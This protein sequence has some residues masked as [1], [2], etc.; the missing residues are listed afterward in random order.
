MNTRP[1]AIEASNAATAAVEMR[2]HSVP[3]TTFWTS[4]TSMVPSPHTPSVLTSVIVATPLDAI[5]TWLCDMMC[6]ATHQYPNPSSDVTTVVAN[7]A[8]DP[9]SRSTL[10][11]I[12]RTIR[13]PEA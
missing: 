5:P 12:R 1:P 9:A 6:V 7:T 3:G 2:F 4:A 13:L 8:V 10:R 11:R